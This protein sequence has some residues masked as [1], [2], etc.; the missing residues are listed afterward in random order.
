[1]KT[2][3]LSI[4]LTALCI[5]HY[6][7]ATLPCSLA[8]LDDVAPKLNLKNVF[9]NIAQEL[10]GDACIHGN[11]PSVKVCA[12]TNVLVTDFVDI[13]FIQQPRQGILM[14]DFMKNSLNGICGYKIFQVG[15]SD[16]F[17]LNNNGMVVLASDKENV[18]RLRNKSTE[19]VVG[20][21]DYAGNS[22]RIFVR[23]INIYTGEITK[24][25]AKE[26][27]FTCV[28]ESLVSNVN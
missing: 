13:R 15:F 1:M 20:T 5:F 27:S 8:S 9:N 17:L 16:Y 10:C 22:L 21:Y 14:G 23:K 28:G 3:K 6:G 2:L 26:I 7:C 19:C 24:F 18:K 25:V 12:D 4:I 11:G